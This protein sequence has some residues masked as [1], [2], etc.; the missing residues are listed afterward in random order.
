MSFALVL[1]ASRQARFRP[2]TI[3]SSFLARP[4]FVVTSS[5]SISP[6]SAR[7]MSQEYKLKSVTSLDLKPG[8]KQEVEL[9][10]LP[11]AKV[12]LLNAGGKVQA[13]APRCT[14]A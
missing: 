4:A 13:I 7:A 6:I 11:D 14:R 1:S 2:R 5:S 12:L 10:G 3:Q 9:E 8:D